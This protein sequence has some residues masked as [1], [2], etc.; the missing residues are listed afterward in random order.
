MLR[1]PGVFDLDLSLF[2][3]FL[4]LERFNLQFRAESFALTNTPQFANPQA[5]ISA[6]NF[7]YITTVNGGNRTVR[8][9]LKLMF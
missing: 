9:G 7:G 4:I 6:G 8:L 3:S 2:R 5:N 1:G